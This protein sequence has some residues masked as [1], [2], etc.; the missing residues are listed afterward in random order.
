MKTA[1]SLLTLLAF[2]AVSLPASAN[3]GVSG[4]TNT[5]A[6]SVTKSGGV[7]VLARRGADDPAGHDQFDDKGGNR[8]G[9]GGKG[10]GGRDDG[11]NHA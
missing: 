5:I 6:Q 7:V 11:L 4:A 2:A 1:I 10:R 9:N 3:T 8:P